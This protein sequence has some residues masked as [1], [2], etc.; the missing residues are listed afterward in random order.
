MPHEASQRKHPL[1][2]EAGVMHYGIRDRS[3]FRFWCTITGMIVAFFLLVRAIQLGRQSGLLWL[4]AVLGLS[5][6]LVRSAPRSICY[7]ISSGQVSATDQLTGR[8]LWRCA[9]EEILSIKRRGSVVYIHIPKKTYLV[10][11]GPTL[12]KFIERLQRLRSTRSN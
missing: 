12:N 6:A 8:L 4:V 2:E 11:T 1:I 5:I 9:I 7:T 3:R 10:Y